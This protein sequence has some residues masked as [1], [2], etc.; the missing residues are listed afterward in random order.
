MLAERRLFPSRT[1]AAGAVRS[2]KVRVGVD[3]PLALRPS[4]LIEPEAQLIVLEPARASSRAAGSSSRTR[5][6]HWLSTSPAATAST[7]APPQAASSTACCSAA[8]PGSSRSTSPTASSRSRCARTRGSSSSSASTRARWPA[9]LP[10]VPCARHS[11][12][13]LHL[14]AK[15]LPAIVRC[16]RRR[17]GPRAGQAAVRGRSRAGWHGCRPRPRRPPRGDPRRG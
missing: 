17:R 12:R 15:V 10:F 5:W 16:L 2:G 14:L 1:A 13:L 7:S 6:R 11:R 9:D 8:P 3:G 4:Q